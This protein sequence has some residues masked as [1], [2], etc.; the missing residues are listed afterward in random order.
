MGR[1]S[2]GAPPN[3]RI[4]CPESYRLLAGGNPVLVTVLLAYKP[5]AT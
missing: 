4:V 3:N 1:S 5:E 2:E